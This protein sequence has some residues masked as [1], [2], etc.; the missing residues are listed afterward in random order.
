[1]AWAF[2]EP[3]ETL[4][5]RIADGQELIVAV[6]RSERPLLV[7]TPAIPA[8]TGE[9]IEAAFVTADGTGYRAR[10][11]VS[12][13]EVAETLLE[14][15]GVTPLQGRFLRRFVPDPPLTADLAIRD[16]AG[17]VYRHV[18]GR[19]RDV[20]LAG[21]GVAAT[22]LRTGDEVLMTLTG[23]SDETVVCDVAA[24]VVHVAANA[25]GLAFAEPLVAAPALAALAA[26]ARAA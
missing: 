22:G 19:V 13:R 24:T 1:M 15:G 26:T 6:R 9:A 11:H 14:L 23:P 17:V 3:G 10:G 16:E 12:H 20:A 5:L 4:A 21:A 8:A 2:P 25:V 7:V 18:H